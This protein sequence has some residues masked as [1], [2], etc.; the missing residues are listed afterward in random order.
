MKNKCEVC[1]LLYCICDNEK[2]HPEIRNS[3]KLFRQKVVNNN[4][5]YDS[6]KRYGVMSNSHDSWIVERENGEYVK[7]SDYKILLNKLNE[8]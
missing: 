5:K 8:I 4:E 2:D 6:V 7:Y 3:K 1:G